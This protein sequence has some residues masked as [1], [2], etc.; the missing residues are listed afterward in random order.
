MNIVIYAGDRKYHSVLEPIAKE[1][2][3]TDNNFLYY[4]TNQT[5]LQFPTHSP[6][7][8]YQYDG[9]LKDEENIHISTTLGLQIPFKPDILILARERWAPEQFIIEE[10]KT[11]WDCKVCCVEVSSHLSNNI[12]NRLEMLSRKNPPQNQVDYFFE[13]SEW[14]KKRRID[15]LDEDFGKKSIVVGNTR[16]FNI[17]YDKEIIYNKYNI[18]PNKKQ[19]LFWGVINTTRH[20]ALDALKILSEKTQNTHQIFYKCYPGEPHN[21]VFKEQFN[22][23]CIPGVTVIYDE[24]DI[25]PLAE[26]CDTHIAAAS[27]VF[28]FAFANNKKIV[29]IDSICN[30]SDKM[31]DINCYI[32]ETKRGVEDS[33]KFWMRVWKLNTIEEFKK[34]IDLKRIKK[35]NQTNKEYMQSVKNNTID[36]DWGCNFLN[37]PKKDYGDLINYFD[38]Y[39]LD[40]NTPNRIIK[41]LNNEIN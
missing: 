25:Y 41:F 21:E 1:L 33:A 26:I 27:S 18:D 35:F 13:H 16:T 30:A 15:C 5:Q 34:L 11:K 37:T 38:S 28:N 7:E 36:F 6:A 4:Y 8:N 14:A 12:E 40:K 24:N 3:K 9:Q 2:K 17:N 20:I 39:N 32:N 31:N 10:F 29:N 19:I 23:F 22:P